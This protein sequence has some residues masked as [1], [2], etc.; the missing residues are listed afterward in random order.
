MKLT[1]QKAIASARAFVDDRIENII[2]ILS[3]NYIG[4]WTK[5]VDAEGNSLKLK[6]NGGIIITK[7]NHPVQKTN[8]IFFKA[9][10]DLIAKHSYWAFVINCGENRIV[11]FLGNDGILRSC[12]YENG[13][14]VK[15]FSPLLLGI[16]NLWVVVNNY[17][18]SECKEIK[19][20]KLPN[21]KEFVVENCFVTGEIEKDLEII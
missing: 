3:L 6:K 17:L 1:R 5:W 18:D 12:Y 9:R 10:P 4:D 11:N 2:N 19:G 21:H 13:N 16:N 14:W 20:V 8:D 7:S 15:N